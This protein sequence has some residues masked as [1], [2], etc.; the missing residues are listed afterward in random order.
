MRH[1]YA[2]RKLGKTS[3]HRRAMFRALV[4]SLLRHEKIET[5]LQK[6]KD[7]RPIVERLITLGKQDSVA[8]RRRAYGFVQSKEVVHKLFSEI[9]PR[10]AQRAG[11]YTRIIR[12]RSRSGDAAD[13][14]VIALVQGAEKAA[15]PKEETKAAKKSS[16]KAGGAKKTAAK[17]KEVKDP[18]AAEEAAPAKPKRTR[19]K[20]ADTEAAKEKGE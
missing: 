4:T 17:A 2:L 14:A 11:G 7:L 20:K 3:G 18:P 16:K 5:T 8:R 9:G 12:T 1:G 13:M 19:K 6:A 10:F 15:E